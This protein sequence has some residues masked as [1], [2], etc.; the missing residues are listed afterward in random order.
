MLMVGTIDTAATNPEQFAFSPA[1]IIQAL[2]NLVSE[3]QP[4]G[5]ATFAVEQFCGALTGLAPGLALDLTDRLLDCGVSVDAFYE[6]YIPG[7]AARLGEMWVEDTLSFAGV[8]LG[9]ARLTEVFRRLSPIFLKTRSVPARARRALFALTPGETHALGVVMAADHFQ[10]SVWTVRVELRSD[11]AALAKIAGAQ[12]FDLIGL[13]A[14][15]RRM[16]PAVA[17][18]V[19]ALR[20]AVRP[21]TP[22]VLGGH[23]TALD[24]RIAER[25]GADLACSAASRALA[26]VERCF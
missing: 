26:D 15:A 11:A 19:A 20:R 2:E 4:A 14:C 5:N 8:T 12:D 7:A 24:G 22:I 25:V 16:V 6:T 10:R 17:D 1:L 13:S 23:L 21:G 18:T 9:M 3:R